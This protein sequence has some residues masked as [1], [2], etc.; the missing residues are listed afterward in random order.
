MCFTEIS[1][2]TATL[3]WY[4][5]HLESHI[6]SFTQHLDGSDYQYRKS[7]YGTSTWLNWTV[8]DQSRFFAAVSRHSRLRA[9]LIALDCCKPESE[10]FLYL[11]ALDKGLNAVITL[12]ESD[13]PA[14][15][16]PARKKRLRESKALAAREV[17]DRW[18]A[19]EEELA[20]QLLEDDQEEERHRREESTL[21]TRHEERKATRRRIHDEVDDRVERRG[22]RNQAAREIEAGWAIEDWGRI[23]DTSKLAQLNKLTR[24]SWC[25][26]Y[27]DRV[28]LARLLPGQ[29]AGP[30]EPDQ[31]TQNDGPKGR[32]GYSRHAKIAMDNAALAALLAMN[33]RERTTEQRAD[34]AKLVNR[35]RNRDNVRTKRLLELGMTEEDIK[36][37]GGIDKVF[38]KSIGQ[39]ENAEAIVPEGFV[40][41]SRSARSSPTKTGRGKS[42]SRQASPVDDST[43]SEEDAGVKH[44]RSIGLDDYVHTSN[45][46][47]FNFKTLTPSTDGPDLTLPILQTLVTK[48]RAFLLQVMLQSL[49]IAEGEAMQLDEKVEVEAR[50]IEDA[51]IDPETLMLDISAES[52]YESRSASL[53]L[54]VDDNESLNEPTD[55]SNHQLTEEEDSAIDSAAAKMDETM[56]TL[57]EAELWRNIGVGNGADLSE[58]I[59]SARKG[60]LTAGIAD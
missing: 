6:E 8:S 20:K 7:L 51:L 14:T 56:D 26:W 25:E 24:P 12:E 4:A 59:A 50:H 17:S 60:E 58:D 36:N 9:D 47:I 18:I 48:V 55:A 46:D 3:N 13:K 41:P 40:E 15:N 54:G 32:N 19:R 33:K 45:I 42:V 57:A 44:L 28:R 22:R 49:L 43:V 16:T 37:E 35:K 52:A 38:L 30:A 53:M 27:S 5:E 11:D 31:T 23:L 34:L 10:V 21:K 29:D 2:S 1:A 39:D